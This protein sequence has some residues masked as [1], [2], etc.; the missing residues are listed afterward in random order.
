MKRSRL[1]AVSKSAHRRAARSVPV[2]SLRAVK[3]RSGGQ[4]ECFMRGEDGPEGMTF[5]R[6]TLEKR[7]RNYRCQYIAMSQPHHILKR[8]RGGG[9]DPKNLLD[10][11][12]GCHTWIEAN[13]REAVKRGL[14][15][16]AGR[17]G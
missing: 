14:S 16:L 17:V 9:H 10:V 12:F 3:D 5:F 6:P 13:D 8:S 2:A 11:C 4:C 15:K 7:F 1:N